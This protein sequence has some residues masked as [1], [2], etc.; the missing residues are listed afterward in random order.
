MKLKAAVDY[1]LCLRLSEVTT[2]GHIPK[3]LY[4]YRKHF[5][6]L[7]GAKSLIQ[8]YS[9]EIAVREAIERRC[10]TDT[11]ELSVIAN[12]KFVLQRKN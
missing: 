7:S 3:P 2:I 12:P 8:S 6:S 10:L 9:A 5:S 4:Y 1:D 11:Y